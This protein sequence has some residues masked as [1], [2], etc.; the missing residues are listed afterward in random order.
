M[1]NDHCKHIRILSIKHFE[2]KNQRSRCRVRFGDPGTPESRTKTAKIKRQ[3]LL[4][5]LSLV[6]TCGIAVIRKE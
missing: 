2:K 1:S 5:I 6:F 4:Y 3:F